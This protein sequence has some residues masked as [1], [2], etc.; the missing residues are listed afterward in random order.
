MGKA[1][2][3]NQDDDD[4]DSLHDKRAE[5]FCTILHKTPHRAQT[6]VLHPTHK[7]EASVDH[8]MK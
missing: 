7:L 6:Q 8:P 1:Q 2:A 3:L 5:V 4:D